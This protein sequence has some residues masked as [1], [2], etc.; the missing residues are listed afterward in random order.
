MRCA[1][2]ARYSSDL[3]SEASIEDQLRLARAHAVRHHMT[4]V[5]EY[6]DRAI[7]GASTAN[8]PGLL[9][10]V[11]DAAAGRFDVVLTESLDRLAR[12]LG[13]LAKLHQQLQFDG[14]KIVTLADG[15][16]SRMHVALKGLMAELFLGDLAQ[17]TRRGQ[18]GIIQKGRSAYGKAY[19]YDLQDGVLSINEAQVAI[20]RRVFA[21]YAAG[22]GPKSIIAAL[23]NA[24]VP[25][26]RGA[27]WSL[28]NLLGSRKTQTGL[29]ACELYIGR[30]LYDRR[31]Y[32]KDPRTGKR[33]AIVRPKAE[34]KTADLPH[35]RI[36][37]QATWNK[38]QAIRDS[39][40][41]PAGKRQQ[42]P[43]HLLSGLVKCSVCGGNYVCRTP[44]ARGIMYLGCSTY[45]RTRTGCTNS[46]QILITQLEERVLVHLRDELLREDRIELAVREYRAASKRRAAEQAKTKS[47]T[48]REL[49]Q[50]R[51][52]IANLTAAI[53]DAGHSKVL[54]KQ[55]AEMEAR[56]EQLLAEMPRSD[57]T[58]VV[59][60]HPNA[61]AMFRQIVD[62]LPAVLAKGGIE[63]ARVREA[64]RAIVG[65]VRVIPTEGRQPV[66]LDIRGD[67]AALFAREGQQKRARAQL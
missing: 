14:V 64:V 20:V 23:N 32:P 58:N 13:D 62:S 30:L 26:P 34:W 3:Q 50:V 48:E 40:G 17:K 57:E 21:E 18:D 53:A 66:E 27:I 31:R 46:R 16:A 5:G 1:L 54:L 8:R 36:I 28:S 39:R 38:A 25:G 41:G 35:L 29:L 52:K 22:V 51:R 12:D 67:L 2:Y 65:E 7:S 59:A 6:Q 11:A 15:E 24:K 19:G 60:L 63:A 56:E 43:K 49:A 45:Q 33:A 9:K 61:G 10:L 55:L 37:D 4:I 44:N 42:H 47:T